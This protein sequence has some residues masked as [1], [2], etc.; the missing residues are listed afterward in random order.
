MTVEIRPVTE[1]NLQ[2]AID[3]AIELSGE[4]YRKSIELEFNAAAGN[5]KAKKEVERDLRIATGKFF[6][7][8]EDGEVAGMAGYYRIKDHPTEAWLGWLGVYE[9][10]QHHGV[11]KLLMQEA[12]NQAAKDGFTSVFRIWTSPE[13]EYDT[14]RAIYRHMGYLEETYDPEAK[15]AG[16]LI[17]VFS[18]RANPMAA[19][20]DPADHDSWKN[21]GYRIDCD[22]Y[23]I[24]DIN[25]EMGL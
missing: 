13:P 16:S 21:S 4:C 19:V 14:A 18:R 1:K 7:A 22:K 2:E 12:F 6:L 11:G 8:Y 15:D 25:R 24:P 17:K 23:T 3:V 9:Q 20:I 5:P 10:H